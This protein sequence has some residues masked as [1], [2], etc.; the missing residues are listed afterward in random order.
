MTLCKSDSTPLLLYEEI[1]WIPTLF[2][3]ASSSL[4]RNIKDFP[5]N[6]YVCRKQKEPKA[7]VYCQNGLKSLAGIFFTA[8]SELRWIW[9]VGWHKILILCPKILDMNVIILA[10]YAL[11]GPIGP[12]NKCVRTPKQHNPLHWN[13]VTYLF[14]LAGLFFKTF[15]FGKKEEHWF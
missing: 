9:L 14:D 3:G 12:E 4:E 15:Y 10:V 13:L 7:W 1:T 2:G 6:I 8:A 5:D 11:V